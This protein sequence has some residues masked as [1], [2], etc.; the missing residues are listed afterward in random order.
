MADP[1]RSLLPG[2]SRVKRALV[3]TQR[4]RETWLLPETTTCP[5]WCEIEHP[6]GNPAD[7]GYH[8]SAD[9]R[10]GGAIAYL[11]TGG[12]VP[13]GQPQVCVYSS[14]DGWLTLDERRA[15]SRTRS[16]Q[17]STARG[18]VTRSE[19]DPSTPSTSCSTACQ[20]CPPHE[21]QIGNAITD[22]G[23]WRGQMA[24]LRCR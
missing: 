12:A 7:G 3:P 17:P 8:E 19:R 20:V 1:F 6:K 23:A 11:S 22:L 18:W 2:C 24:N 16:C 5:S 9:I 4:R 14:E 15:R 13:G 21:A 10:V